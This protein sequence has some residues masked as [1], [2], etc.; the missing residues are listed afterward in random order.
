MSLITNDDIQRKLDNIAH[1]GAER[2]VLSVAIK[3]PEMLFDISTVLYPE[4][5]SNVAN[6]LIYQ[7]MLSILDNK[8]SNIGKVNSMVIYAIAQ[9]SGVT[10]E[11]GGIQYI[12]MLQKMDAGEENLKF[13]MDKVKQASIRR[14]SFRKALSVIDEAIMSEDTDIDTFIAKQEEKFLDILLKYKGQDDIIKIGNHIDIILEQREKSPREILGI[15]TG[16]HEYDKATGGLVPGRLKVIGAPPKTGKSAMALN[17]ATNIAVYQQIPVLFIDTEMSTEEQMDRLIANI[18]SEQGVVVPETAI[19]KGLYV[20]NPKMYD[21]V[22]NYAKPLIKEAPLY[23][24]YMPDFTP[25]RVHN[26]ARKFQKQYGIEW[27]GYK[28]QFVLIFDYIK[29]PDDSFQKNMSEYLILG[30]ITNMLK[31]KTAGQL[32]IPVLAFAQLNPRTSYGAEDVNSTHISGSNRI[33]MFVNELGFIRK[34]T[35]EELAQHGKEMGNLVYK[36]GE[37]RNG[38]NYE[39]WIDYQIYKGITTM[40]ELKNVSL[41]G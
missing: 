1:V 37:T 5:F 39:G 18:A 3:N 9:N 28:N 8:Y 36:L 33:V 17:I 23:H 34:K 24:V 7:I 6:R 12:E 15:P 31:N 22:E 13:Y 35:P 10:D 30:Q 20:R 11:I 19:A 32:G 14:E 38:G 41:E 26:L 16:F 29:L 2:A 27:N 4:D 21:A 40:K 25:E